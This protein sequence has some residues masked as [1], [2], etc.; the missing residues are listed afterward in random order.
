MCSIYG[1]SK[2]FN[3]N[4]A[5]EI[6]DLVQIGTKYFEIVREQIKDIVPKAVVQF[7]VKRSTELLRPKM[8]ENI[9]N[10]PELKDLLTED[11]SI[12]SKRVACQQMVQALRKAQNILNEVR[13]FKTK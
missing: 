6:K 5:R 12:T 8:I 3:N 4:Q 9:F 11:P 7:L 13:I 10:T 1:A 2:E